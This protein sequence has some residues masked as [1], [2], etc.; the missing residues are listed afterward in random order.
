MHRN[1]QA[2]YVRNSKRRLR[3]GQRRDGTGIGG[4]VRSPLQRMADTATA[5][6]PNAATR[7]KETWL[8]VDP[9]VTVVVGMGLSV[10]VADAS[11]ISDMIMD[12]AEAISVL[13]GFLS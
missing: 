10:A 9:A 4:P 2:G 11:A 7:R 1:T 5:P 12:E 6:P 13:D 8:A 3:R